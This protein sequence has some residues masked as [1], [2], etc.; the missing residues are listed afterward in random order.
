MNLQRRPTI[1]QNTRRYQ[2]AGLATFCEHAATRK[3]HCYKISC[4]QLRI[5]AR[6]LLSAK[7][8]VHPPMRSIWH[9]EGSYHPTHLPHSL[10]CQLYPFGSCRT[11]QAKTFGDSQGIVRCQVGVATHRCTKKSP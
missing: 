10:L 7:Y 2:P 9:T 6:W 5:Q 11:R 3:I 4:S 1:K 8:S